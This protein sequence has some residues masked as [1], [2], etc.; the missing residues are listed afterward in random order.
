MRTGSGFGKELQGHEAIEQSVLSFV[1]DAHSAATELFQD[2]EMRNGL[3]D[4]RVW[5]RH[6]G[7][8]IRVALIYQVNEADTK[9]EPIRASNEGLHSKRLG[10][11][12]CE[13][14]SFRPSQF[15]PHPKQTP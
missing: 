11:L 7:R 15:S 6:D 12:E 3:S 2:A 5:V 8:H 10:I 1:D 4:E 14:E 13:F 9:A